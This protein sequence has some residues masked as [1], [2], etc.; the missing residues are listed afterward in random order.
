V[1]DAE[2]NFD[3]IG[4]GCN[5]YCTMGAGIAL[6]VKKKW[7][8]AYAIDKASPFADKGKLGTYTKWKNDDI[9]VLNMYTQWDYKGSD[10]NADYAA[11]RSCMKA[12][13]SEYS[14][15]KIG[16][17]LIGAGLAG[18][19]WHIIKKII[20]E[21]LQGEDVTVVIWEKSKINWHLKLLE[22]NN[23]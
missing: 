1:R 4:H 9:T 8:D 5:C 2:D 15:A 19:E 7:P 17:P 6:S 11:I 21:E 12:V 13:K 20:E 10:V 3:V 14:G 22:T 18:G 16:I 23:V